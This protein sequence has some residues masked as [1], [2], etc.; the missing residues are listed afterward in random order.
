MKKYTRNCLVNINKPLP[1][2]ALASFVML[3]CFKSREASSMGPSST[4]VKLGEIQAQRVFPLW[5]LR[6]STRCLT[7]LPVSPFTWYTLFMIPRVPAADRA[8]KNDTSGFV[9]VSLRTDHDLWSRLVLPHPFP[10]IHRKLEM[11]KNIPLVISESLT[12]A[13]PQRTGTDTRAQQPLCRRDLVLGST[14]VSR[15]WVSTLPWNRT[16]SPGWQEGNY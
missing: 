1:T 13:L 14:A 15:G 10:V 11:K 3:K 16:R 5:L 9:L 6:G 12:C 8:W 2:S 4:I 7:C